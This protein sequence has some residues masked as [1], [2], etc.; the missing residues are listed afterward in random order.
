MR[1]DA[2]G[3]QTYLGQWSRLVAR[4]FLAWL[5]LPTVLGWLHVGGS[6]RLGAQGGLRR[7]PSGYAPR[8]STHPMEQMSWLR[9]A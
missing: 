5:E 3:Y 7:R 1:R 4:R 9:S 6:G 2:A 8:I